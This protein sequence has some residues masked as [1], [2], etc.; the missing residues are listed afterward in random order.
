M[1]VDDIPIEIVD[2]LNF[3]GDEDDNAKI[4]ETSKAQILYFNHSLMVTAELLL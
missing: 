3:S 4:I 1:D 2:N